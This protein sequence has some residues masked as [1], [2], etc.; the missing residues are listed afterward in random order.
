MENPTLWHFD[1]YSTPEIPETLISG[2]EEAYLSYF[3]ESFSTVPETFSNDE[4]DEYVHAYSDSTSLNAA[5][6]Y[7]LALPEDVIQNQ[8]YANTELEMPVLA[9][10]GSDS[11]GDFP[12]QQLQ[13]VASEVSGGTI[14]NTGHYLIDER[15]D[16][17]SKELLN[18]LGDYGSKSSTS[19][20][21]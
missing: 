9:L 11:L 5:F 10:E 1:L 17:I 20:E 12:L 15:P 16:I 6:E 13:E 4:I 19:I 18:F 2:N 14:E 8:E 7:Y 21:F 3:L